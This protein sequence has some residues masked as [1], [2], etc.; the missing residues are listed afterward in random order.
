MRTIDT[1]SSAA[2]APFSLP[3]VSAGLIG[4]LALAAPGQNGGTNDLPPG[5]I[6]LQSGEVDL[7]RTAKDL[8]DLS[9]QTQ[10]FNMVQRVIDLANTLSELGSRS[11]DVDSFLLGEFPVTNEQYLVFV[12][13]TG[14]R[15]PF[16]WWRLG[17]RT[18]DEKS[19]NNLIPDIRTQFP[20]EERS[21]WL[22]WERHF[23]DLPSEL[24]DDR[25]NSIAKQPVIYVSWRDAMAF[26]AWAGMRLPTEEE[27]TY[28]ARGESKNVWV[29]ANS[30]QVDLDDKY[31]AEILEALMLNGSRNQV[32]KD[33]GV[34]GAAAQGP[35]GHGD[36]VGQVWEWTG[37]RFG[38]LAGEEEFD[39]EFQRLKRDSRFRRLP[40]EKRNEKLTHPPDWGDGDKF[41]IKGGSYLSYQNP[42]QLHIDVRTQ[43]PTTEYLSGLGFR[44]AKSLQPGRDAAY[45]RI[46]SDYDL[47]VFPNQRKPNL[48]DQVGVERYELDGDGMIAG[49]KTVSL[50]PAN[51]IFEGRA[52]NIDNANAELQK[53]PQIVATLL[54]TEEIGNP[55]LAPGLY[56]IYYRP[57]GIPDEL[58][59]AL[60]DGNREMRTEAAAR[61]AAEK[62]GRVYSPPIVDAAAS[63]WRTIIKRY[64]IEESE[65]EAE[66]AA[67]DINYIRM[68]PG[69]LTVSTDSNQ[70]IVRNNDGDYKMALEVTVEPTLD[71]GY[72]SASMVFDHVDG[73]ERFLFQ[74]AVPLSDVNGKPL[75]FQMPL[76]LTTLPDP[77][78]RKPVK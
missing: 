46:N 49:Y 60:K 66:D 43:L 38:P 55:A 71:A 65:L 70:L 58:E 57:A 45:S 73:M 74:F 48:E 77:S 52:P 53:T 33:V 26:A 67:D 2:S 69:N 68:N 10:R 9:E 18:D 47:S 12:E 23:Q 32:L 14:H 64:G 35:F 30:K 56:S 41:V 76:V 61:A 1:C 3:F 75:V 50:V 15:F 59:K 25:G 42:I 20:D 21:Q 54:T 7:G 24:K 31:S 51:F 36:M 39:K 27:W 6:M 78:W 72:E 4:L 13:A 8:H 62:A 37:S 16:H 44:L 5:F 40:E 34:T 28:A 63:E 19:Y 22:Y 17:V 29:W 11:A